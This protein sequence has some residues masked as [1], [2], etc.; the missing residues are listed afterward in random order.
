VKLCPDCGATTVRAMH[1]GLPGWA[2]TAHEMP[3][4]GGLGPDFAA[5]FGFVGAL[6][7]YDP[8]DYWPTLWAWLTGKLTED[9]AS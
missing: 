1:F 2:C 6:I 4:A 5:R 8:G 9:S 3:I 7:T